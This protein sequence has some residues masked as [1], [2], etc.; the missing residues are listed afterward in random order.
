MPMCE[1]LEQMCGGAW[2]VREPAIRRVLTYLSGVW[3]RMART[4]PSAAVALTLA[5][6]GLLSSVASAKVSAHVYLADEM[7]PLPLADPNVPDVYRDVMVGTRLTIFVSSDNA[8]HWSGA[9]WISWQSLL[10]GSL[11]GREYDPNSELRNYAGSCLQAAGRDSLVTTHTDPNGIAF[12]L[13]SSWDAMIGDWFV[14]DYRATGVGACCIGLYGDSAPGNPDAIPDEYDPGDPPAFP[15]DLI[16]VLCLHH[17]ISRDFSDDA[18]V[19]FV[20]FAMLAN[21]WMDDVNADA[22]A[23]VWLD[24]DA[25]GGIVFSD[26]A[27]F[28]E[29]WLERSEALPI[30]SGPIV[31]DAMP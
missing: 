10:T 2:A 31:P 8:E 14:L 9:L 26:I 20:D 16:Q 25:D 12:D 27:L 23:P 11:S 6:A 3:S 5:F 19:N 30:V 7:T 22:G 24:L 1:S 28:S 13:L 29:Y 18:V 4:Y 17:V 21:R 15:L